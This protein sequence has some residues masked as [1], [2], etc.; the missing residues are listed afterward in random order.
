LLARPAVPL[1]AERR[2]DMLVEFKAVFVGVVFAVSGE[3]KKKGKNP[4]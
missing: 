3:S 4:G 2:G 1:P